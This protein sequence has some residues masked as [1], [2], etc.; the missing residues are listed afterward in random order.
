MGFRFLGQRR[1]RRRWPTPLTILLLAVFFGHDLLDRTLQEQEAW[2]GTITRTY[3]EP[4]LLSSKNSSMKHY[5]D[6]ST[7]SG[8]SRTIRVH[9]KSLWNAGHAGDSVTKFAG[10]LDPSLMGSR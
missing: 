6:I 2:Q 1:N 5:W 10:Q 8:E 9:A 7:E 4:S 3:K